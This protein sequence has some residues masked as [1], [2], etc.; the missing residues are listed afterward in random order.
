MSDI[1][2]NY[3]D[4]LDEPEHPW[5]NRLIMLGVFAA[6][7][8]IAAYALW[9]MVLRGEGSTAVQ[10]QTAT[11]TRGDI[12]K[13]VSTSGTVA[14]QSTTNLNFGTSGRVTKVY[15]TLG[16]QVKQG[17]ALAE[18]DSTDAQSALA[19]ARL[20]LAS[21]QSKLDQ[22]LQGSTA[23]T[24]ASADQSLRQAQA[25]YGKAVRSLDDLQKPPDATTLAAAQQAVVSAQAQLQQAKDARA[26]IDTDADAAVKAAQAAVDKAQN[27]LDSAEQARTNAEAGVSSSQAAL[28]NAE[29]AY[30][31]DVTVAFCSSHTAPISSSDRAALVEVTNSGTPSEAA[32]A[33]AVLSANT[34][35]TQAVSDEQSAGAAVDAADTGLSDAEDAL[36]KAEQ[37]PAAGQVAVADAAIG[38]AQVQVDTA[39]DKLTKLLAGPT[40]DDLAAAQ[41]DIDTATA[42][43]A[44]AQAKRDETY[45]GPQ[46]TDVQQQRQSVSQAQN[47][48]DKAQKDLDNTKL[49]APFDGTVAALNIQVGDLAGTGAGGRRRA[50]R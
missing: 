29:T 34:A 43:L 40:A 8:A 3:D 50:R 1:T 44:S 11:V 5:R 35:Y 28:Y 46:A 18:I 31:P 23:S 39:Q 9:A 15:A 33:S 21:A 20:S 12:T 27:T 32:L 24:L 48:V 4:L 38:S 26:K 6:L 37:G 36:D 13:S 17:D 45:A 7:V 16:R 49:V 25:N 42:A 2:A 14:A 22:L 41:S 10:E 19:S 30:C 47:S